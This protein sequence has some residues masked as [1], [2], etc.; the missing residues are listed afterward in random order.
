MGLNFYDD[1][2]TLFAGSP[3][4]SI[5]DGHLGGA[6]E[7]K[8]YVRNDDVTK[9]FTNVQLR[10]HSE[11]YDDSGEVGDSGWSVKFLYGER[12][13]T[14]AEWD[15]VRSGEV[16]DLPDIGTVDLADTSTYH[17]VWVRVY[18]PGGVLAQTREVQELRLYRFVKMVGP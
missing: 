10:L 5:H 15:I 18:C 9:Y 11:P 6:H 16:L 4:R 7:E 17:P 1:T 8:I 2:Q 14:E 12:R 13:P 3:L